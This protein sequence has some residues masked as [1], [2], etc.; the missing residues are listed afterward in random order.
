M[1]IWAPPLTRAGDV[2]ALLLKYCQG[3]VRVGDRINIVL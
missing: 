2:R 3:F 1:K